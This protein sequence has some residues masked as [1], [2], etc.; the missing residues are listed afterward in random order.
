[1]TELYKQNQKVKRTIVFV[2]LALC[3]KTRVSDVFWRNENEYDTID[4]KVKEI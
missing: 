2:Q 3:T 4:N 1:M